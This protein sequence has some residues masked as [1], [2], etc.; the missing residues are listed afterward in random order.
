MKSAAEHALLLAAQL[1]VGQTLSNS[2]CPV[3]DGGLRK[4]R[5][6]SVTRYPNKLAYICYRASCGVRGYVNDEGRTDFRHE[7][8]L[9]TGGKQSIKPYTGSIKPL[10]QV[11]I[12]YF[13][14]RFEIDSYAADK[15]IKLGDWNDYLLP[16]F[17]STS[18]IVGHVVRRAIW[19]GEPKPVRWTDFD[20]EPEVKALTRMKEAKEAISFYPRQYEEFDLQFSPYNTTDTSKW[21]IVED[22]ISAIKL[23]AYGYN[24]VALL[25]TNVNLAKIRD[26]QNA[27]AKQIM[28]ALDAD[29][30]QTAFK[31]AREYGL[32]FEKVK[33]VIMEQ[34]VKDTPAE[35]FYKLFGA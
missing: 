31:I 24:A 2:V 12:E 13:Y 33:A 6:F 21:I 32:A 10:E 19:K 18:R 15:F 29:A 35:E 5:T 1:P 23:S 27:G 3:C 34:D 30:T 9:P 28:I 16:I 26:M 7:K 8:G 14:D 25:S 4:K 11:D 22:Q 20:R 17:D